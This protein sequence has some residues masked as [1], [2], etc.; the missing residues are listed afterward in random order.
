MDVTAVERGREAFDPYS[1]ML[2]ALTKKSFDGLVV[3]D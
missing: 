2:K 3:I 1:V